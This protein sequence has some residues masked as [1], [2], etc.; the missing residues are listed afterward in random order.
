MDDAKY[1]ADPLVPMAA[2]RVESV[3]RLTQSGKAEKA[4][5]GLYAANVR[6]A[7]LAVEQLHRVAEQVVQQ[8]V[9]QRVCASERKGGGR[10]GGNRA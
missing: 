4:D 10:Q 6:R 1:I 2:W 9:H 5:P 8:L 7:L 3:F